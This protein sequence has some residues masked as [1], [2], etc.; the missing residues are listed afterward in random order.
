VRS[1]LITVGAMHICEG[2]FSSNPLSSRQTGKPEKGNFLP[3]ST[4]LER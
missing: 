3:W 4:P 2:C 1:G